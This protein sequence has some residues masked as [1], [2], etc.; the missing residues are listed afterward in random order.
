MPNHNISVREGHINT[1]VEGPEKPDNQF[2]AELAQ[3]MIKRTS[4]MNDTTLDLAE[5]LKE[6]RLF[7]SWSASHLKTTWMDWQEQSGKAIHDLNLDRMAFDRESKTIIAAAKD[8]RDFFNSPEYQAA[9]KSLK[10]LVDV[11]DRFGVL[12]SNGTL[13]AFADFIL[14][15]QK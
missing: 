13:D 1:R 3:E 9:H 10:E 8:V 2:D 15:V 14:K 5:R 6:A 4:K 12:K 11:L 7:I